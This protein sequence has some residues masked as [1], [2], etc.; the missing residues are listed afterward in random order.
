MVEEKNEE[1]IQI[2]KTGE[3]FN[4]F[5]VVTQQKIVTKTIQK[6]RNYNV[7]MNSVKN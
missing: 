3:W 4:N 7:T 5:G 1:T 6:Y 2:T